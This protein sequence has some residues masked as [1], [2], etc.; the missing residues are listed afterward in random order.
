[1]EFL[2]YITG[3]N[4][5]LWSCPVYPTERDGLWSVRVLLLLLLVCLFCALRVWFFFI[6][7]AGVHD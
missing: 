3:V 2:L 4:R 5:Y 7:D 6:C 1:M